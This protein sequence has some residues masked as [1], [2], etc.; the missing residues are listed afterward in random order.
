[1]TVRNCVPR[2]SVALPAFFH[3][4]AEPLCVPFAEKR[5]DGIMRRIGSILEVPTNG[6][7]RLL[8]PLPKR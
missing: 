5:L 3:R 7:S 1:M 4:D 8:Q 2:A 6:S